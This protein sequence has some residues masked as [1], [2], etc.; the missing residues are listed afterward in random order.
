M[1]L[2]FEDKFKR[3]FEKLN[4]GCLVLAIIMCASP[5]V[6]ADSAISTHHMDVIKSACETLHPEKILHQ[7]KCK[8]KMK[9]KNNSLLNFKLI[10]D[11]QKSLVLQH[12]EGL[13][14][15]GDPSLRLSVYDKCLRAK[16]SEVEPQIIKSPPRLSIKPYIF[17]E[18]SMCHNLPAEAIDTLN[19]FKLKL[20]QFLEDYVREVLNSKIK[21]SL[22]QDFW[23]TNKKLYFKF[24]KKQFKFNKP[25]YSI[26]LTF[27]PKTT[28]GKDLDLVYYIYD[29]K[30]RAFIYRGRVNDAAV[31]LFE[32][33]A[34]LFSRLKNARNQIISQIKIYNPSPKY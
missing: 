33:P 28:K 19:T 15:V 25:F 34:K 7:S 3:W 10:P 16:I 2:C 30:T 29:I 26:T 20:E 31:T 23:C 9:R 1:S 27:E 22:L 14:Y 6:I 24:I 17:L 4:I 5:M 13:K 8:I 32:A 12:C 11:D 18:I 21:D